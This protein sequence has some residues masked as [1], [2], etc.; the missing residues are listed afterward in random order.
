MRA[1]TR[2][3]VAGFGF[4]AL[5]GVAAVVAQQTPVNPARGAI[6]GVVVDGVTGTAV[7]DAIVTLGGAKVP[8]GY[9]GRQL[10]DA[11]GRFAFVQVP[12]GDGFQI[13]VSKFGYLDGGYGRETGPAD[14][15]RPIAVAGGAWVPNIRAL[16][17]RPAAITGTV[18]DETGEPVVGV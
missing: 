7:S 12:D 9:P 4:W 2:G 17:W 6:T 5:T 18:C 11:K 13:S 8:T 15:L 16:I 14:A 10:T 3:T 1:T